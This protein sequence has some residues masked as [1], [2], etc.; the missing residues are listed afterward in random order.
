MCYFK[1]EF[2]NLASLHHGKHEF[3]LT[4]KYYGRLTRFFHQSGSSRSF[5][6]ISQAQGAQERPAGPG[7]DVA[8][9]STAIPDVEPVDPETASGDAP[10]DRSSPKVEPPNVEPICEG[11]ASGSVLSDLSDS[12]PNQSDLPPESSLFIAEPECLADFETSYIPFCVIIHYSFAAFK[13]KVSWPVHDMDN[14][15]RHAVS[16]SPQVY[17]HAANL[18]IKDDIARE[19]APLAYESY[20]RDRVSFL[21]GT[22]IP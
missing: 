20:I 11:T 15:D 9:N 16:K 7:M 5:H 3:K 10:Y 8:D 19:F 12:P 21:L 6:L 13:E 2:V 17:V 14:L 4:R 1:L 22:L 18:K